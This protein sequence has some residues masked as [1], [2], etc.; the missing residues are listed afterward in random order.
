MEGSGFLDVAVFMGLD[1]FVH[2]LADDVGSYGNDAFAADSDDGQGQVVVTAVEVETFRCIGCDVAGI[3]EVAAGVFEADDVREVMSQ[4]ADR[5]RFDF[6]ACTARYVIN[7][8]RQVRRLSDGSKVSVTAFLVRF[9]VIRDDA[10]QDVDARIFGLLGHFDSLERIVGADIAHDQGLVFQ[11]ICRDLEELEL[12]FFRH[13]SPFSRRSPDEDGRAF[14][15]IFLS[16]FNSRFME[17]RDHG[18]NHIWKS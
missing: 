2:F 16:Q 6:A 13:D 14:I 10:Q 11:G 17:R 15:S 1:H 3:I 18:N 4:L 5:L 9:I 7:E 12:F 8:D